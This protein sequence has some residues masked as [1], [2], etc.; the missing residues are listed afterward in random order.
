MIGGSSALNGQAFIA[1][2]QAGIDAWAKLGNPTW[3]WESMRPYYKKFYTL[4]LPDAA[5]CKHLGIDWIDDDVKGTSGPIQA[6]FPG[7]IQNPL[8][9]AWIDAFRA[10]GFNTTADPFSGK[11]IGAYS[12]TAAIDPR[13]MTRSFSGSAYGRPAST[14]SNISVI[15]GALVSRIMLQEEKGDSNLVATGVEFQHQ[16]AVKTLT[17]RREVI[18]SAGAFNSPK[19]LELSGIGSR[20]LLEK[21]GIPVLLESEGVGENLQ[22]HVMSGISFELDEASGVQTGDPLVRKEPA[23]IQ[24]AMDM[25]TKH[26]AGPMCIGGVQSSAFMPL[27]EFASPSAHQSQAD[28]FDKY[29]PTKSD[30]AYHQIVR[31]IVDQ[32]DEATCSMFMFLAQANL[33]EQDDSFVGQQLQDGGFAS[34]GVMQSVPF[35]R[36]ATHISSA[37]AKDKPSI[38]PRFFS[39]PLDIEIMARHL[40]SVEKL[41]TTAALKPYFKHNGRRNHPDAFLSNLESAKKYLRDTAL[42]T[43]H[44]CGTAAMMPKERGGVVDESLRVY[45]TANLRVCDASVFPLIPRANPMTTVY[46]VAEKMADTIKAGH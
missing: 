18:V 19:L 37:D 20:S 11:S 34:F 7:V 10:L 33:H 39:H 40:L 22:D 12:N 17:A 3:T 42:T 25:Y 32:P 38:D 15:T 45:G 2:S 41:P 46:A 8:A 9:K 5:T 6:S 16:H 31:E 30:A 29:P 27:M 44:S 23:A 13:T 14:R 24:A 1:P 35:S 28:L 21:H 43:Y 36:G 4:H 26:K